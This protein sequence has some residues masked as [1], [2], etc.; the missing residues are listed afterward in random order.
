MADHIDLDEEKRY[1]PVSNLHSRYK[2]LNNLDRV[3]GWLQSG[4]TIPFFIN[5]TLTNLCNHKCPMCTSKDMLDTRTAPIERVKELILELKDLGVKAIGLGGGGDPTCH[6]HYEEVL[7]FIG[8]QGLEIG[9]TT[10]GQLLT[11]G[12]INAAVEN[13]T[14]IRVSLDADSPE[15]YR[16]VHGMG[17][18]EFLQVQAN[19]AALV[20][21]KRRLNSSITIGTT[22]L[23]GP[24]TIS[25]AY[26]ATAL[27]KELGVDYIR[28][29][30]FFIWNSKKEKKPETNLVDIGKQRTGG[31]SYDINRS[32]GEEFFVSVAEEMDRC[33]ELATD[34]FSVSF[35]EN[36]VNRKDE[37]NKRVHR[38]CSVHHFSVVVSADL[39]VYPCCMLEDAPKYSMGSLANQ[40]F[41][42]LWASEQRKIAC[43]RIDF[44]DC[45]NPCMSEGHNEL[46][47][48]LREGELRSDTKLVDILQA[49][50]VRI[51]HANFL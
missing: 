40:S 18:D 3:V 16:K 35:P 26:G 19:L 10:N 33:K 41:K 50:R 32:G 20:A 17:G 51:P 1:A 34:S 28:L 46:L 39:N 9:S 15:T 23:V 42:Q 13:C 6:P 43:E 37:L 31:R 48:E 7:R 2:L 21:E 45:P 30:P 12:M 47:W 49:T 27:A 14:W 44:S 29:R 22:F 25:K 4:D 36:R 5:I 11:P 38:C 24:H 8:K